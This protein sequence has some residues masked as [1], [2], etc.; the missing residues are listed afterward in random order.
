MSSFFPT[1]NRILKYSVSLI[2]TEQAR[3]YAF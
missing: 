3:R 2:A 1:A